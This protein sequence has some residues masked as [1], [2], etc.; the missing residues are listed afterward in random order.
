[1]QSLL[2]LISKH[3][4]GWDTFH[5]SDHPTA[6]LCTCSRLDILLARGEAALQTLIYRSLIL[7]DDI[8]STHC[9]WKYCYILK[10]CLPFSPTPSMAGS[11][12]LNHELSPSFSISLSPG[13]WRFL[14]LFKQQIPSV[15]LCTLPLN[16]TLITAVTKSLQLLECW[17]PPLPSRYLP[18]WFLQQISLVFLHSV[19][20]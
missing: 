8:T 5:P 16:L 19:P 20:R 10:V 14:S 17:N 9:N 6:F 7:L 18:A 2:W 4:V 13:R 11:S 15:W 3:A 1:M 12:P